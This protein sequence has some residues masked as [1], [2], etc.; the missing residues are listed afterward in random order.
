[1]ALIARPPTCRNPLEGQTQLQRLL[2]TS[3]PRLSRGLSCRVRPAM[4]CLC[5]L[6]PS[7]ACSLSTHLGMAQVHA[8]CNACTWAVRLCSQA[9]LTTFCPTTSVNKPRGS[10]THLPSHST[11]V[12]TATATDTWSTLVS[13]YGATVNEFMRANPTVPARITAGTKIFIPPCNQGVLQ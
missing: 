10:T 3:F 7:Y 12:H 5:W 6:M 4:V 2:R 13:R 1:M 8:S 11:Q 9:M